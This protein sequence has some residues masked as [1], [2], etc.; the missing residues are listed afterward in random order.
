[1]AAVR[2]PKGIALLRQADIDLGDWGK[3]LLKEYF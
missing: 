3:D 1:M 2:I